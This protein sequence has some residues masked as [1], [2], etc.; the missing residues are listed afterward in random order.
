[1]GWHISS[2]SSFNLK[3]VA[4]HM[5]AM[6]SDGFC[7]GRIVLDDGSEEFD[8]LSNR[9]YYDWNDTDAEDVFIRI[10]TRDKARAVSISGSR[11]GVACIE[12]T[13]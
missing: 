13:N 7:W 1:M 4:A 3:G 6:R 8:V 9:D 2:G 5:F 11:I 12:T 10:V